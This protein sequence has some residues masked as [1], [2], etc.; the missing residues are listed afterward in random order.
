MLLG[1]EVHSYEQNAVNLRGSLAFSA[2]STLRFQTAPV[3]SGAMSA[4]TGGPE[5]R[6]LMA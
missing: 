6:T 1:I 3:T 4:L 5:A 2:S